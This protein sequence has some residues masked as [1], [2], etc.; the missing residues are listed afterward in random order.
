[1]DQFKICFVL[2]YMAWDLAGGEEDFAHTNAMSVF[3]KQ[4]YDPL[5]P[6]S[7]DS[8]VPIISLDSG[9]VSKAD[10]AMPPA[11]AD[12]CIFILC[13]PLRRPARSP[14]RKGE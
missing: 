6:Y 11:D 7:G 8:A 13:K 2:K 3:T 4:Q 12:S 14:N 5:Y 9:R 10:K 1:M